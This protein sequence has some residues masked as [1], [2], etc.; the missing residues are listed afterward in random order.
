M[1]DFAS[2]QFEMERRSILFTANTTMPDNSL[3]GF[4]GNPNNVTLPIS[5]PFSG[6][7]TLIY[8]SPQGT[9]YLELANGTLWYKSSMQNAWTSYGQKINDLSGVAVLTYGDQNITGVKN[10]I[11]RPTVNNIPVSISGD[12]TDLIH[13]YGKNDE[14]TTI[15]KGQP[16]YIGGANGANPLIKIA[17]STEERTSSKTIGLLAQN[18]LANEF[19]HI[20]TEGTLEGFNTS[21]GT[22]GD[23]IWL[24]PTGSLLFGTGN[25]PHAPNHLVYLGVVLRSN[26]NNGK[27]YIRTQNGYEIDELHDVAAL[28]P[29]NRDA[30]LYNSTSGLWISRQLTSSDLPSTVVYTTGNQTISGT[31]NFVDNVYIKNLF[32]TGTETIV[33]TTNFNVQSPYLLLNLTGG[34]IDGG[35][36]FVTGS[37]LTGINDYGPIIGFDHSKNFKFGIARRSDDLAILNDI[38][39][40]QDIANYSG[41]VNSNFYPVNNPSGFITGVDLSIYLTGVDFSNYVTKTSGEFFD[42]PT[43]NGTGVLLSGEAAGSANFR[44]VP[45]S[46]IANLLSNNRYSFD[47]LT[48]LVVTGILPPSPQKGDE[49]ELYDSAGTWHINPLIIDNNGNYIEQKKEQLECNVRHG[50]IK[51][52]YTTQNSIGWRIYP[53]PIHNVPIF[54]PPSIAITGASLSGIIPFTIVLSGISL[55]DPTEAPV[56]EWHWNLNTGDGYTESGQTI[57]YTYLQTGLY[58]V[59]LSGFNVAGFDV[60]HRFINAFLPYIPTIDLT[61]NKL[62]GIIPLNIIFNATNTTQ[63]QEYSPVDEWQWDIDNDGI[64]DA[65]GSASASYTFNNTGIYNSTAY[66]SN[67]GGTGAGSIT[68]NAFL[69]YIPTVNITSDKLS[70][71]APFTGSLAATNT[72]QPQEYSPVDNWYWDF[73]NDNIFDATGQSSTVLYSETGIYTPTAYGINLGGTG[74]ES[75]TINVFLPYIPTV[76]IFTNKLSGI[77]PLTVDFTGTN[78]IEP[79]EY[80]PVDQWQWDADNDGNIDFNG[81][82]G[83]FTYNQTGLYNAT[84]YAINLG[85]TGT[86]IVSIDVFLPY[87]PTVNVTSNKLSGLAPFTGQLTATNTT[88]PAEFSPVDNW[89]W[90]FDGDTIFDGT[91]QSATVVYNTTGTYTPTAYGTNLG[92]TGTGSITINVIPPLPPIPAISTLSMSG[93]AQSTF[94]FTGL[95]LQ[96]PAEFSPV[97]HWYWNI[98]G[99]SAPEFD[100]RVI[101]YTFNET[102]AY[103]LYLTAVNVAGSGMA[104]GTFL[105]LEAP[106]I[107]VDGLL[108]RFNADLG[109]S[110]SNG[111]ITSWTDQQNGVIAT[112]FN[113]PTL[114]TNEFNGRN[115]ISF[116]GSNDFFNGT[117]STPINSNT[118]RTFAV[119]GK[120]KTMNGQNG[121]FDGLNNLQA[122]IFQAGGNLYYNNGPQIGPVAGDFTSNYFIQIINTSD[123]GSTVFRVDG[124]DRV[125]GNTSTPEILGFNI[126]RGNGPEYADFNLV[127]LLVYNRSLTLEEMELIETYANI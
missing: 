4:E 86:G 2:L 37:G 106:E 16:V 36:F 42:R 26:Q 12:P 33:S 122:Y 58:D 96:M 107:P 20:I 5:N 68:I 39:A 19:G 95:N 27:A 54:L 81:A 34:A 50:L 18:L 59:T 56:D 47:T 76:N 100:Q 94:I 103:T 87:V 116:D 17:S 92:G 121:I 55:L 6:G 72:T 84:A 125:N 44:Y 77:I 73:D 75:I 93:F 101:S 111:S 65:S 112:G 10:F 21:A 51:L 88:Q 114:L 127:E 57:D 74:A 49:I 105:I 13:L 123:D 110:E 71:I 62:S 102:G 90:D 108:V 117:F 89:Y 15:Y 124:T 80:S 24:G 60:E 46:G 53:M 41:F 109:I 43:V 79:A 70:G 30:L 1:A 83:T 7:K 69:P 63:P 78:T 38:A 11:S 45:T 85:G 118:G 14:A 23:P 22:E 35:I 29:Q 61:A 99:D 66:A 97:D 120:Y 32:V 25:K 67:L 126:G 28:N 119:I 98:S 3:L 82:T 52:I 115:A 9:H 64:I 104:S 48:G 31:K 8:N 113:G 40:V 91:G